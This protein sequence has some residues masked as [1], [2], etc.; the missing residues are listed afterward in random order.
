MVNFPC[1]IFLATSIHHSYS[2]HGVNY[3][4]LTASFYWSRGHHPKWSQISWLKYCIYTCIIV[5]IFF[6]H[7]THPHTRT[8]IYI[9]RIY[10]TLNLHGGV[11]SDNIPIRQKID[12]RGWSLAA[13]NWRACWCPKKGDGGNSWRNGWLSALGM[14]SDQG[15]YPLANCNIY[16]GNSWF[17]W[18][19]DL[20]IGECHGSSVSMFIY[21]KETSNLEWT[22]WKACWSYWGW[23]PWTSGW[24]RGGCN[25][26]EQHGA[27]PSMWTI[28]CCK[29]HVWSFFSRKTVEYTA[30]W[31]CRDPSVVDG[32]LM[33]FAG[34]TRDWGSECSW[35]WSAPPVVFWGFKTPKLGCGAQIAWSAAQGQISSW[36]HAAL[37]SAPAASWWSGTKAWHSFRPVL[38]ESGES[39]ECWIMLNQKGGRTLGQFLKA[40]LMIR[41]IFNGRSQAQVFNIPWSPTSGIIPGV[42][43]LTRG[44]SPDAWSSRR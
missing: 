2:V 16:M 26:L 34:K 33:C 20:Y 37:L 43:W 32:V 8:Y 28:F 36:S 5:Y 25:A 21:C 30:T 4:D 10:P 27:Y 19:N 17:L 11:E 13:S 18:E 39:A 23:N 42:S 9:I 31:E 15:M 7:H 41:W 14:Y 1:H 6:I 38:S 44:T 40:A 12:F 35:N 29:I 3:N 22:R 24:M